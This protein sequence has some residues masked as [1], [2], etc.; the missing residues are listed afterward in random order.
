MRHLLEGRRLFECGY[1]KVW[2]LLEEI[3]Y[4]YKFVERLGHF[5]LYLKGDRLFLANNHFALDMLMVTNP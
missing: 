5:G 4:S 3:R 1:P 2:L